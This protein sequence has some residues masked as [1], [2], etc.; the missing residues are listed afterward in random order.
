MEEVEA[1]PL[2]LIEVIEDP[3][4]K[5]MPFKLKLNQQALKS[6]SPSSDRYVGLVHRDR[7]GN[8]LRTVQIWQVLPGQPALAENERLRRGLDHSCLHQGNLDLVQPDRPY[9]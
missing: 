3:A 4:D 7:S 9:G 2:L 5:A 1:K 8:D 6:L